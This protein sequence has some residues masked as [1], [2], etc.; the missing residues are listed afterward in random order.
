M[1]NHQEHFGR[2]FYHDRRSGYWISTT[3]NPRLRAHQWVWFNFHGEQPKGYHVHHKNEDKSDNSI[4]N[5]ELI[6]AAQHSSLHMQCPER[7]RKAAENCDRIRPLTKKWHASPEGKKWHIAHGIL[8]WKSRE[9]FEINCLMCLKKIHTKTYHQKYCHQ[10]CKAK[11]KRRL[12]KA[13]NEYGTKEKEN[14]P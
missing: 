14:K 7:K 2:K 13:E 10:N 4:E 9:P 5:L 6:S 11:H 1:S 12:L 3:T 8:T